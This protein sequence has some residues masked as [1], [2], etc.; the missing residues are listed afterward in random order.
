MFTLHSGRPLAFGLCLAADD[1]HRLGEEKRVEVL[2][3]EE[4]VGERAYGED[5]LIKAS[6][7]AQELEY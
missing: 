2:S 4:E 5:G 1:A 3:R 7:V 6:R